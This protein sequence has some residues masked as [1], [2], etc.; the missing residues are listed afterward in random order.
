M[1]SLREPRFAGTVLLKKSEFTGWWIG[2]DVLCGKESSRTKAL[3]DYLRLLGG[4][5]QRATPA[6]LLSSRLAVDGV[7][8]EKIVGGP[9]NPRRCASC[10]A[11]VLA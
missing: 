10:D 7:G 9:A 6:L 5:A 11:P 2:T 4:I 1:A 3:H 8:Y